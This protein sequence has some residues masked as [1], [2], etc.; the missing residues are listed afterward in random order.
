MLQVKRTLTGQGQQYGGL[1]AVI[2][3]PSTTSA[4]RFVYLESLPWFMKPYF[5]TLHSQLFAVNGNAACNT[6]AL[7]EKFYRPSVDRMRASHLELLID[8]PPACELRLSY[9]FEKSI[10]RY[11][12]YPPDANRGFDVAPAVIRILSVDSLGDLNLAETLGHLRTTSLLL[13]LPT[14]GKYSWGRPN[15]DA[16]LLPQFRL[17][18]AIQYSTASSMLR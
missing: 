10:L 12:E 13:Y 8:L 6:E 3:N 5:H 14:P 7:A 9:E 18:Y 15:A 17:F 11:T 16:N 1:Q 2:Q 4:V